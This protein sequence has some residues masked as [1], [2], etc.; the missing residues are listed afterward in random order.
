MSS[1]YPN[2]I[3]KNTLKKKVISKEDLKFF[4]TPGNIYNLDTVNTYFQPDESYFSGKKKN[5]ISKV[6][7]SNLFGHPRKTINGKKKLYSNIF[8]KDLITANTIL[9]FCRKKAS[10]NILEIGGGI[11]TLQVILN[12]VFINSNVTLIDFKKNL[13]I[14]K[15]HITNSIK[16]NNSFYYIP[17]ED[18]RKNS[19]QKNIKFDL[20]INADS[21]QEMSK[22]QIEKYLCLIKNNLKKNGIFYFQ[23]HYLHEDSSLKF[24]EVYKFKNKFKIIHEKFRENYFCCQNENQVCL[25]L[26]RDSQSKLYNPKKYLLKHSKKKIFLD[27]LKKIRINNNN[28]LILEVNKKFKLKGNKLCLDSN[29][30]TVKYFALGVAL[31]PKKFLNLKK[32]SNILNSTKCNRSKLRILT[33][34]SF[35]QKNF[36]INHFKKFFKFNSL[37]IYNKI[38]YI[39]IFKS[40][41]SILSGIIYSNK[42][43]N[44]KIIEFII[45]NT[46]NLIDKSTFFYLLSKINTSQLHY[47]YELFNIL[48]VANKYKLNLRDIKKL[49]LIFNKNKLNKML[50][51]IIFKKNSS[52]SYNNQIFNLKSYDKNFAAKVLISFSNIKLL[53]VNLFK[54]NL[55]KTKKLR[56]ILFIFN[57]FI[58][59]DKNLNNI[60]MLENALKKLIQFRSIFT[61][62]DFQILKVLVNLKK[63]FSNK[64]FTSFLYAADDTQAIYSDGPNWK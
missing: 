19:L 47:D 12:Q 53:P 20:V 59:L 25:I 42:N 7:E 46:C 31:N 63:N 36:N 57:S 52:K 34:Y 41:K 11:G 28:K 48:A 1:N 61:N 29:Y 37:D 18:F 22:S 17:V 40:D 45:E 2:I 27:L 5:Y 43:Y 23:N 14:Q 21:M 15:H 13:E 35:S 33:I 8:Y 51:G 64:L 58:Y 9:G 55:I 50:F 26:K 60:L 44:N 30:W 32:I 39:K 24:S 10:L 4:K 49:E 54:S 38:I 62:Y 16:N 56:E 3:W 6:E